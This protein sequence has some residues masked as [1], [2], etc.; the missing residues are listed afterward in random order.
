MGII[1]GLSMYGN[2]WNTAPDDGAPSKAGD[3]RAVAQIALSNTR[4]TREQYQDE[5]TATFRSD[6]LEGAVAARIAAFGG[7]GVA[8]ATFDGDPAPATNAVPIALNVPNA[9]VG[10]DIEAHFTATAR[11]FAGGGGDGAYILELRMVLIQDFGGPGETAP[12]NNYSG[13]TPP[14]GQDWPVVV[15]RNDND[16]ND[17]FEKRFPVHLSARFR[18]SVAGTARVLIQGRSDTTANT[19]NLV[20]FARLDVTRIRRVI[21]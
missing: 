1:T 11:P 14:V 20:H 10:E 8:A 15:F 4:Y 13:N 5:Y 9:L 6:A 2:Q 3:I 17:D 21:V 16:P 7:S 12:N 19:L 18:V